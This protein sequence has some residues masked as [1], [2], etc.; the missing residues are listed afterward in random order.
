MLGIQQTTIDYHLSVII[1]LFH[2]VP[3]SL[4]LDTRHPFIR[5]ALKGVARGHAQV[6][7]QQ[8]VRSP[9]ALSVLRGGM[10][11]IHQW[12]VGGR[13]LFWA[14]GDSFFFRTRA[15]K[16]FAASKKAM[17]AEYGLKR[18]DVLLRS[19]GSTVG[20]AVAFSRSGRVV[21]SVIQG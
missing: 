3:S 20:W 7:T 15:S 6:G 5:N 8:Q 4:E 2:R 1:F 16:M 14:L 21:F 18:G 9:I 12:R 13:E 19:G 11:L 17:H 10:T